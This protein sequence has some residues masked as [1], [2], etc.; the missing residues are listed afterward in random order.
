[1]KVPQP[2]QSLQEYHRL[3]SKINALKNYEFI[4]TRFQDEYGD[5]QVDS[6][7]SYDVLWF[8]TGL[9]TTSKPAA[10]RHRYSNLKAFFNFLKNSVD[11]GLQNFCDTAILRKMFRERA[12]QQW[13]IVEKDLVDEIIIQTM[14]PR[15]RLTFVYLQLQQI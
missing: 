9:S 12:S 7:T 11:A 1:M 4:F 3:N 15:N 13:K 2:I 14:K 5:R 10:K 8:L 6:I